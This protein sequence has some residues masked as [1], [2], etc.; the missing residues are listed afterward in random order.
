MWYTANHCKKLENGENYSIPEDIDIHRCGSNLEYAA[1]EVHVEKTVG[2]PDMWD[3]WLTMTTDGETI[4]LPTSH[5]RDK[6][7]DDSFTAFAALVLV[8]A[9]ST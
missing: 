4:K 7:N 3:S 1:F 8:L 2:Q 6:D 5:T 9:A